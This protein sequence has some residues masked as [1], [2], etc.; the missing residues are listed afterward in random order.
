MRVTTNKKLINMGKRKTVYA[1][2][3]EKDWLAFKEKYPNISERLRYLIKLDIEN[4]LE[5]QSHKMDC[6]T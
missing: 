6:E 2:V 4:R 3:N 5:S 1:Y